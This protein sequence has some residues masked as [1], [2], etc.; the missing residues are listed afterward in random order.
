MNDEMDREALQERVITARRAGALPRPPTAAL[1]G[2]PYHLHGMDLLYFLCRFDPADVARLV[3]PGLV[4][5][6][7]SWG[8]VAAYQV[9][10]GWEIA[11]Y[12]AHYFAPEIEG[13]ASP[14]GYPCVYQTAAYYSDRMRECFSKFYNRE[15]RDGW[16]R[17]IDGD[18]RIDAEAGTGSR[19]RLRM[20]GK[21]K[22][23]GFDLKQGINRYAFPSPAGGF[24]LMSAP[25]TAPFVE[26]DDA[27]VEI[28]GS[29]DDGVLRP[30]EIV[31]PVFC[32]NS[33][34]TFGVPRDITSEKSQLDE[35]A[36]RAESIELLGRI[37]RPAVLLDRD[38]HILL[39]NADGN[40]LLRE[41]Q[42]PV[43]SGT[44]MLRDEAATAFAQGAAAL[45]EGQRDFISARFALQGRS[46]HPLLGLF[47]AV[48]DGNLLL[49]IDE[50]ARTDTTLSEDSLRILGLTPAEAR[51]AARVG[52]GLSPN[53][54]AEE[55]SLS[56]NT[57]RAALKKVY[58]KLAIG[59]QSELARI[60]ARIA[61]PAKVS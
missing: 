18:H 52:A 24:N 59:R 28:V 31:W 35:D 8:I 39:A 26:L 16:T 21:F 9:P 6:K 29:P 45:G 41:T 40:R 47:M 25:F 27:Y 14:D 7:S 46:D 17:L 58:S 49:L 43:A 61:M 2:P 11:P 38:R 32:R 55:L 57:V 20:G 19:V 23:P 15:T 51:I 1:P 22:T 10:F 60:V 34:M 56:R 36:R 48:D 53:A 37:G 50:P 12:S 44:L 5:A 33:S 30:V 13:F 42:L 4:P 3:P 54:V